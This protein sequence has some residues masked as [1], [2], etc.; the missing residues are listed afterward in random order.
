MSFPSLI[1]ITWDIRIM[2]YAETFKDKTMDDKLRYILNDDK[3]N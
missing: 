3:Q 2:N 1:Y